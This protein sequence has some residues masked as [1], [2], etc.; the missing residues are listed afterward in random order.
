[1]P[2]I[3][4]LTPNTLLDHVATGSVQ[5]GRTNRV[6]DLEPMA[7]G[8]GV[9]VARVLAAHGHRV[10]AGGFVGSDGNGKL[11]TELVEADGVEPVFTTIAARQR[12]GVLVADGKATTAILP[13]GM[14]VRSSE[15]GALLRHVRGLLA[16]V[17]LVILGG[18]VPCDT[19]TDLIRQVLD[20]CA[21]AGVPCWVDSY[22]PAMDEALKGNH[23]PV[24]AKPNKQEY[25]NGK[26]WLACRELHLTDGGNPVKVR[27]PE[28][29]FRVTAPHITEINAIGSGDSYLAGLAHARLSGWTLTQQLAYASAAGAANAAR[30]DVAHMRPTEIKAL[31]EQVVVEAT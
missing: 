10:L 1:M 15:I 26:A 17:D 8:K 31:M 9:N 14:P 3:L 27:A 24:L 13:S 23:P 4:T 18:S 25:G 2:T 7:A 22:G 21:R 28:G 30:T 29:R 6:P 12:M 11:F 19:C 16:D 5:V 20:L